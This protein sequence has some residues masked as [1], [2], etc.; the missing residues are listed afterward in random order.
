MAAKANNSFVFYEEWYETIEDE[1][2]EVQWEIIH[3]VME[4]VFRGNLVEL[5]P[6][7]KMA[8]KF[9]KKDID[10]A[11][12]NYN[13]FIEKQKENGAKGGRPKTQNNPNNPP[14]FSETQ[15]SLNDNDN[16]NVKDKVNEKDNDSLL[17][18]KEAKCEIPGKAKPINQEVENSEKEKSSAKKEKEFGKPEFIGTLLQLGVDPQHAKDWVKIREKKKA[19]PTQTALKKI[20][21]DCDKNSFPI[22]E[23]IKISAEKGWAGFSYNWILNDDELNKKYNVQPINNQTNRSNAKIDVQSALGRIAERY[24][25][26]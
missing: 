18:E 24:R 17:L 20:I 25:E 22:A 14:V 3:A 4:Y 16:D 7:A 15:K 13:S 2:Q 21:D 9:I 10:R 19:T 6:N 11:K 8:F 12:G 23:A 1:R 26:Q 5:R